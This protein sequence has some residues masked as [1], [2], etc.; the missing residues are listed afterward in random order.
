MDP[1]ENNLLLDKVRGSLYGGA[2]GDAMGSP[3]ELKPLSLR[4][5]PV[6]QDGKRGLG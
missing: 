1:Q 5:A 2:I 3:V 6:P 4:R